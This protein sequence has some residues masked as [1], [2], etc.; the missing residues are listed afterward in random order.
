MGKFARPRTEDSTKQHHVAAKDRVR[1]VRN[2][3]F[4]LETSPRLARI[5]PTRAAPDENSVL[6]Q[7]LLMRTEEVDLEVL[8]SI[9]KELRASLACVA[10]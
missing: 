1:H 8:S 2:V 6:V 5:W 7:V 3:D 10:S 4:N 9:A